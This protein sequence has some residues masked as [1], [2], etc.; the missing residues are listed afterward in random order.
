M[1][2]W[3]KLCCNCSMYSEVETWL[4]ACFGSSIFRETQWFG[5]LDLYDLEILG[6]YVHFLTK[7]SNCSFLSL[8]N[9]LLWNINVK[10]QLSHDLRGLS[11]PFKYSVS[12]PCIRLSLNKIHGISSNIKLWL[13]KTMATPITT[14]PGSKVT[15]EKKII[16]T[17][18]LEALFQLN[19]HVGIF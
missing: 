2:L 1:V 17:W 14:N 15:Q 5:T 12:L 7:E 3:F 16:G 13:S 4:A 11:G 18:L 10:L 6:S 8:T 9:I 19:I